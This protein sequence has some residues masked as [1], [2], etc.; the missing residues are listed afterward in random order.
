M[1]NRSLR[2]DIDVDRHDPG[3]RPSFR[4]VR[5]TLSGSWRRAPTPLPELSP[6]PTSPSPAILLL[7][8]LL[9][10]HLIHQAAAL[11]PFNA[12]LSPI[13]EAPSAFPVTSPPPDPPLPLNKK[14]SSTRPHLPPH[15]L[16][17][18][19]LFVIF[20]IQLFRQEQI[21]VDKNWEPVT[22]Y[23]GSLQPQPTSRNISIF[24]DLFAERQPHCEPNK[25]S[26]VEAAKKV[27]SEFE[28]TSE[29]VNRGVEEFLS[30]MRTCRAS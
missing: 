14:L 13:L 7:L 12:R 5:R 19:L 11:A 20:L 16:P 29:D 18:V 23:E 21:Q 6:F 15:L 26:V 17:F 25:M 27:A 30:Q 3:S 2:I 9:L 10:H 8:L 4:P 22:R 24:S 28:Y 1:L